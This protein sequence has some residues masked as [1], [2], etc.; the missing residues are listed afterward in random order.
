MFIYRITDKE[1]Q[2]N[3]IDYSRTTMAERLHCHLMC[4]HG[5]IGM[6]IYNKGISNFEIAIIDV[7][8]NEKELTEALV[9]WKTFYKAINE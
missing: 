8:S 2:E 3:Y 1:T 9:Y 4:T 7:C 6:K 5:L